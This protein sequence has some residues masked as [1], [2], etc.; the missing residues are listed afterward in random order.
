MALLGLFP[1][2]ATTQ[3]IANLGHFEIEIR[4]SGGDSGGGPI[5]SGYPKRR[6]PLTGP[7]PQNNYSGLVPYTYNVT[8]TINKDGQY[9]TT[10]NT[11]DQSTA[12]VTADLI[13]MTI[14]PT[15][16]VVKSINSSEV[17]AA[18]ITAILDSV[19]AK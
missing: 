9:W 12:Q 5:F 8:I 19:A 7:I 13:G 14:K 11:V 10:T 2:V 18:V 17:P 6:A 4:I 3:T 1:G 16:V 15:G